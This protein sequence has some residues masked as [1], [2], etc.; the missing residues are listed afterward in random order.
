M[1]FSSFVSLGSIFLAIKDGL[2]KDG[3]TIKIY[4]LPEKFY[5]GDRFRPKPRLYRRKILNL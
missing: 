2:N 5:Q 3:P 4:H 1:S